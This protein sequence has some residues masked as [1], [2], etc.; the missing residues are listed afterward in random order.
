MSRGVV[1]ICV[2]VIGVGGKGSGGE[3]ALAPTSTCTC[4]LCAFRSSKSLGS[5]LGYVA[6]SS[7]GANCAGLTNM[8]RT[9]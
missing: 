1:S 2:V 5:V 9:V 6:R 8:E 3:D 4:T 7:W